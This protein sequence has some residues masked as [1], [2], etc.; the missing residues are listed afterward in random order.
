M[1][2]SKVTWLRVSYLPKST[3]INK[4]HETKASGG[5]AI[6]GTQQWQLANFE[7]YTIIGPAG[8]Q[9]SLKPMQSHKFTVPLLLN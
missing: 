3:L 5:G 8:V 7:R 1:A 9:V 6:P 4:T 2:K